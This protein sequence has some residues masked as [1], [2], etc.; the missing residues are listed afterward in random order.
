MGWAFISGT[1][2]AA[3][4]VAAAAAWLADQYGITTPSALEIAV[5][6]YSFQFNSNTDAA[7]YP[8]NIVQLPQ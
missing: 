3:P 6:K 7:G 1:S 4:F 8:V 2:M 5:R